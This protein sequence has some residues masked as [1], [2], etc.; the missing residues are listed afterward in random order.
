MSFEDIA[1]TIIEESIRSAICIDDEFVEPYAESHTET[2]NY[3]LAQQ[4]YSAFRKKSCSLDVYTYSISK[5][6]SDKKYVLRNRDLLILDWQLV[7]NPSHKAS[8][9][10]L[11][12]AIDLPSLPFVLIYTNLVDIDEV[13]LNIISFFATSYRNTSELSELYRNICDKLEDEFEIM[14]DP[15]HVFQELK[16][17]CKNYLVAD[18]NKRTELLEQIEFS[19]KERLST[20]YPTFKR[21]LSVNFNLKKTEDLV[22]LLGVHLNNAVVSDINSIYDVSHIDGANNCLLV[23]DTIVVIFNKPGAGFSD[24]LITPENIFKEFA[25][26]VNKRPRNFLALLSLEMKNL[27]RDNAGTMGNGLYKIDE[28]AFFHHQSNLSSNEEFYDFLKSCWQDELAL[29]NYGQNPI[30]FSAL[31]YY[32]DENAISSKVTDSKSPGKLPKFQEEL[33]KLN[34]FYSFSK[35]KRKVND[36][37]RFGDFF[38]L[39]KCREESQMLNFI[40]CITAHCDCS[41]PDNVHNKFYF[42]SGYPV[43][44]EEGLEYAEND[45]YSF[46]VYN[47]KPICIKW[48]GKPFTLY[49]PSDNN[50]INDTPIPVN[51]HQSEHFLIYKATLKENYAQRVANYSFSHASR[52]GINLVALKLD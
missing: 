23:N 24:Y 44:I 35:L 17:E 21:I 7:G 10:I 14:D 12:E 45:Y 28:T 20:D 6:D 50:C 49:I 9:E 15:D 29:F 5:W 47:E 27:Y 40:L 36:T 46:F 38:V 42:V 26:K 52:V 51:Y 34:H 13:M 4:L 3:K 2:P 41:H 30:L 39:S 43:S 16:S 32:K 31:N 37:I 33:V 19:L 11:R 25:N 1:T 18:A 48:T 22:I 8:L